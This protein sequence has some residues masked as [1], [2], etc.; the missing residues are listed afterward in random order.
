MKRKAGVEWCEHCP[1]L[2]SCKEAAKLT[3]Q[4]RV[5]F[6]AIKS[7]VFDGTDNEPSAT[8][9]EIMERIVIAHKIAV[10]SIKSASVILKAWREAGY[11]LNYHKVVSVN[12][13]KWTNDATPDVIIRKLG[14]EGVRPVTVTEA[15]KIS[16][17]EKDEFNQLFTDQLEYIRTTKLMPGVKPAHDALKEFEP[18]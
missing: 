12:A 15:Q 18:V 9:I 11:T 8:D 17:L 2:F 5:E 16:G 13:R 6:D 10:K 14:N 3:T 7:D 1:L 4:S